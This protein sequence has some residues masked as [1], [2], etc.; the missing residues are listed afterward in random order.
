[1]TLLYYLVDA[2]RSVPIPWRAF[3]T[4]LGLTRP[5]VEE[6]L[7]L[8]NLMN[9]GGGTYTLTAEAGPEGVEVVREVMADTFSQPAR[10]SPV[11]ARALLL[12]LDL[13]GDTFAL[14]GAE[15]LASVRREGAPADRE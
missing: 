10:L 13:L 2:R 1:M 14:E 3:E 8:I 7:S 6:D 5:E 9:F 11:L 12:A 4:D 15:S